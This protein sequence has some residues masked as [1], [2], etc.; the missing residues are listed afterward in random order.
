MS[1]FNTSTKTKVSMLL[2]S[3]SA[4]ICQIYDAEDACDGVSALKLSTHRLTSFLKNGPIRRLKTAPGI[5]LLDPDARDEVVPETE[6]SP[7][8]SPSAIPASSGSADLPEEHGDQS[9]FHIPPGYNPVAEL[10]AAL[11]ASA[12]ASHDEDTTSQEC[13]PPLSEA[14]EEILVKAEIMVEGGELFCP[15]SRRTMCD[16]V[17]AGDGITYERKHIER[18]IAGKLQQAQSDTPS[19]FEVLSPVYKTPI[20]KIYGEY[21]LDEEPRIAKQYVELRQIAKALAAST[22]S[23]LPAF[24]SNAASEQLE[25][26]AAIRASAELAKLYAVT[27]RMNEIAP[28]QDHFPMSTASKGSLAIARAKAA[29]PNSIANQRAR[30]A[31]AAASSGAGAQ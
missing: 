21:M 11:A 31:A 19:N 25:L 18:Y 20:R 8:G 29:R 16:P 23:E 27:S 9:L 13:Q 26:E 22:G 24:D 4:A 1:L 28:D 30:L 3:T 15:I 12:S 17:T 5:S 7:S 10:E 14:D 2:L 6:A